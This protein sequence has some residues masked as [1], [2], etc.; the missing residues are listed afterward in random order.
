MTRW[1]VLAA[2]AAL[3][4]AG[5]GADPAGAATG[6][7]LVIAIRLNS[8]INPV[9]ASF[10]S[11]SIDRARS[12]HAA[13]L[14]I[15][16]DT[17][18][19]DSTSMNAIVQDELHSPV[20]VIVYVAPTGARA[21]SAG[22]VIA[23]ASDVA[24]MAPTTHIGAATPID[25]SGQNLGSD[26]R[27]KVLND[28]EAQMRGLAVDH[29]RN[30]ALA[31]LIVRQAT[32]YTDTE[33]LHDN[34]IEH[35]A[36]SLPVLLDQVNGTTTT[37][38]N[39]RIVLHTAGARIEVLDMPWTLQLLNI[40]IDPN[41]LYLLFLAGLAGIAYEVFHPGVILP[42]TLGAI[43]L[44]LA[45]FGFSIVPINWAGAAL[46]V[47]GVG[48]LLLEGWV[49]S[50][51]L[52]GISGVL[53]LCAGGL[54]LFRTPGSA[55]GVSPLLVVLI[56]VVVGGGLAFVVTKVVAARHQPVSRYAAGRAALLGQEAVARTPLSPDGQV[57]VHGELWRAHAD[58]RPIPAGARVIVRSVEGMSLHVVPADGPSSEGAAL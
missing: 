15:L 40:L 9:S 43:S 31:Q 46:I 47:F 21:A 39:K 3:A 17:P 1:L 12:D 32:E 2:L 4:I 5:G 23:M 24:A 36:R 50:H 57:F 8:E 38:V 7:P 30:P 45:L 33:A 19:G 6:R 18:G 16:L 54:L 20:P 29:G 56:G 10:V 34:L 13:A 27:R 22:S 26:L 14:V 49:T 51:G 41:L 55:V 44:V 37:Y 48:L 25:A 53:A 58:E 35:V 11:D 42:G 28:A 52:I